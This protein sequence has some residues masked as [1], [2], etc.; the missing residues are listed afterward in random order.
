VKKREVIEQTDKCGTA[1]RKIKMGKESTY[2]K[3]ENV[4]FA[5]Y[6]WTQASGIPVRGI[7]QQL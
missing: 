1:A 2:S 7:P 4:F 3:L 5:W 6:K